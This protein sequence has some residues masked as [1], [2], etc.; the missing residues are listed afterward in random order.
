M[1]TVPIDHNP[2]LFRDMHS[3]AI[4]NTDTTELNNY[5]LQRNKMQ[6]INQLQDDVL[7]LKQDMMTIKEL[8]TILVNK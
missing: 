4:L 5:T 6:T 1:D 2:K 3:K 8:L 7:H